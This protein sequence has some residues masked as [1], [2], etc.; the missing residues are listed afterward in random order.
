M[1]ALITGV[2]GF[3]GSSLARELLNQGVEVLGID[4]LND[5]YSIDLKEERLRSLTEQPGFHF[6]RIDIANKSDVNRVVRETKPEFVYHLA[7]Q[8]GVR[9]PL[10]SYGKYIDSNLTGFSNVAVSAVEYG[11]K[12][13]LY[14][15]SSSVY[16]NST[17]L[18][19]RETELGLKPVSFYG[20]TKY[21]N[22]I[23]ANTISDSSE[24]RFRGM[25]F[26]TVYGPMG[27]PDMAYFRLIHCA[28]NKEQFHLFG[29]GT[30]RRD[31]TYISDVTTSI[32]LLGTELAKREPGHADVVN[33]G[34]GKPNSISELISCINEITGG[35]IEVIRENPATGDVKETVADHSLQNVLTGFVPQVKLKQ[36]I[37]LV[38]EWAKQ[39]IVQNNLRL[40]I[41]S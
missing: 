2:A 9:L 8:A 31:F 38:Y 27:R 16:G 37:E 32:L 7:A 6:Q 14:A 5:Y 35:K 19:Y 33:V 20:A 4:N 11:V 3:I 24:T 17:Q 26:F 13:F 36:G 12:Q 39:P 41:N 15:S 10:E 1:K 34:G 21:A 29:D 30:L 25:R 40:W 18:P 23:L 28:L 22:E